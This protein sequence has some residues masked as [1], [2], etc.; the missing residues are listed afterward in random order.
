MTGDG[1]HERKLGI[2][3]GSPTEPGAED[4]VRV[5]EQLEIQYREVREDRE[6]IAR[7]LIDEHRKHERAQHFLNDAA[8]VLAA[9]LDYD[10]TLASIARVCVPHLA[11]STVV[12][13][14]DADGLIRRAAVFH[15]NAR[16]ERLLW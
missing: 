13:I 8:A 9:N 11:D 7:E 6:Q 10:A 12:D 5:I 3:G 16:Q 2:C 4:L 15:R 14:V 1:R